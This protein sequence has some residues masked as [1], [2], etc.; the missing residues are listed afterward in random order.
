MTEVARA[1]RERAYDADGAPLL[2]KTYYSV[3]GGFVV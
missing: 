1:G 3:G 2:E